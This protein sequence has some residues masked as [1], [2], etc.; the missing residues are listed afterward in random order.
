MISIERTTNQDMK[1]VFINNLRVLGG[2]YFSLAFVDD[3]SLTTSAPNRLRTIA[4]FTESE[5]KINFAFQKDHLIA[6]VNLLQLPVK[7]VLE[8]GSIIGGEERIN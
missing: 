5:C 1:N 8:N 4:S 6:M 2:I 3:L 7:C